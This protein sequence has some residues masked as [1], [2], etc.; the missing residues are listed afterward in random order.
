MRFSTPRAQGPAYCS[1]LSREKSL[2]RN[3]KRDAS[4]MKMKGSKEAMVRSQNCGVV[5][6]WSVPK[7]DEGR[8][9]SAARRAKRE[10]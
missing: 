9:Q 2:E 6:K 3:E 8:A 1:L 7:K 10:E 4:T 5:R